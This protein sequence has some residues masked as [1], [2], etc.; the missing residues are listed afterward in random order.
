MGDQMNKEAVA[1]EMLHE[2]AE[3][4]QR[5]EAIHFKLKGIA[6]RAAASRTTEL[7]HEGMRR[8]RNAAQK[9]HRYV[10][11]RMPAR[12]SGID[13]VFTH[14]EVVAYVPTQPA[15]SAQDLLMLG[16]TAHGRSEIISALRRRE[17]S[18]VDIVRMTPGQQRQLLLHLQE[19]GMESPYYKSGLPAVFPDFPRHPLEVHP[20][21]AN[22]W[23]E[24]TEKREKYLS[25]YGAG[26]SP[27]STERQQAQAKEIIEKF[28]QAWP[29]ARAYVEADARMTQEMAKAWDMPLDPKRVKRVLNRPKRETLVLR[30]HNGTPIVV[31][32]QGMGY[33]A[34]HFTGY[35]GYCKDCHPEGD[36]AVQQ[37]TCVCAYCG[38]PA[39]GQ[40]AIHRD[41]LGEGPEVDL[42]NACG[43]CDDT[44]LSCEQIWEKFKKDGVCQ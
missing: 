23:E 42:C 35:R 28:Y 1:H 12:H 22:T 32:A 41:G 15:Y 2:L 43:D 7:L 30:L 16:A 27:L 34:K 26:L 31:Q 5:I 20:R 10:S 14:D 11:Y 8:V 21:A 19:C 33:C 6:V 18:M 29:L 24:F 36:P 25:L 38:K 3:L 37:K 17:V 4:E 9:L 39:Q 40:Y 44:V 13:W